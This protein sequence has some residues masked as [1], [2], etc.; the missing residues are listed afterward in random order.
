MYCTRLAKNWSSGHHRTTLSSCIFMTKTRID[1]QK[2]KILNSNISSTCPYNM[3][4]VGPLM[5][6]IGLPVWGTPANFNGFRVLALSL[7]RRHSPEANHTLHD[8]WPSPG[9]VHYVCI[10]GG[11]CLVAEFCQVQSSVHVQN[12]HSPI[13]IASL[14]STPVVGASQT[15]RHWAE[16]ATYIRQGGHH[17]KH[18]PTF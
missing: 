16:G 12:L 8:V 6:E 18:W 7:Q 10:F 13:F 15:L 9:L 2:K 14:H 5:A 4:N 11:S 17:V 1:N 3:A